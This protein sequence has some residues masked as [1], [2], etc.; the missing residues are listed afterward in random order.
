MYGGRLNMW[1]CCSCVVNRCN[2][3]VFGC[4]FDTNAFNKLNGWRCLDDTSLTQQGITWLINPGKNCG[5]LTF[6]PHLIVTSSAM[7]SPQSGNAK[8]RE[9]GAVRSHFS[10]Y[11]VRRAYVLS[12]NYSFQEQMGY[13]TANKTI[14][15]VN[16]G[17][18][19][20]TIAEVRATYS[21]FMLLLGTIHNHSCKWQAWITV[22]SKSCLLLAAY[23]MFWCCT[24]TAC[25]IT[26]FR[27]WHPKS[28][29]KPL[30]P[31]DHTWP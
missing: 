3:C 22:C 9:P 12:E 10:T 28:V 29:P 26:S 19:R 25:L 30:Q 1:V 16:L 2:N 18:S 23:C 13:Y 8:R 7:T 21:S 17:H 6:K 15:H 24:P 31:R 27:S 4:P 5:A 11:C 20:H 14:C